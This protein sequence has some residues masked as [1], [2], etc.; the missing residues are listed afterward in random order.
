VRKN[1]QNL[2]HGLGGRCPVCKNLFVGPG[3][4]CPKCRDKL[5]DRKRRKP[6]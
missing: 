5:R 1:R 6:R 4:R 2:F 3:D